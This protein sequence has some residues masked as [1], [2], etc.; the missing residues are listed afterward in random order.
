MSRSTLSRYVKTMLSQ[1]GI[2]TEAYGPHS[3][4][5][6]STSAAAKAGVPLQTLLRAAGWANEKIFTKFY[7]RDTVLVPTL[8]QALLDSFVNK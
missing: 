3:T 1:A 6:A 5:A 2:A 4:R 8:G 7:R